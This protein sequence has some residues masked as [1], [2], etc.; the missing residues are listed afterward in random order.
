MSHS[1]RL[2]LILLTLFILPATMLH[3][4]EGIDVQFTEVAR[5]GTGTTQTDISYDKFLVSPNEELIAVLSNESIEIWELNEQQI[6]STIDRPFGEY[7]FGVFDW[8]PD[9]SQIATI[10]GE[11][12][13]FVWDAFTG[14]LIQV[15]NGIDIWSN[16][17]RSIEWNQPNTITTGSFEYLTWDLTSE[18]IPTSFDCH[19]Y[20]SQLWWSP[21]GEYIA[22][23]G[24]GS[25]LI[26]IC[27]NQFNDLMWFEGYTTV[28]WNPDSTELATVGIF[29][30]LRV[31]SLTTREVVSTSR[32]G[33]NNIFSISWHSAGNIIVTGHLNGEIRAWERLTP[34]HF[35]LV[36]DIN[37]QGLT[38]VAWVEDNLLTI[39][40]MG[41]IQIW[42][43]N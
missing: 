24:G 13:L 21:N 30:T 1:T 39:N 22:T 28:E 31:W 18:N 9:G 12:E 33:E 37:V 43:I 23:M 14:D 8:S 34:D 5:F 38:D 26:W 11:I 4:Q 7:G 17:I 2:S 3:A 10:T 40:N 42:A 29:N 36:G 15:H 25:T 32:A 16:G 6:I 27:D 35:W 20:G 41:V 19:P